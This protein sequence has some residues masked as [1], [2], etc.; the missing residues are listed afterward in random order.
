[1]TLYQLSN[2]Y[3]DIGDG[4][5][6][7]LEND[8]LFQY[9]Y[10]Y[11]SKIIKIYYDKYYNVNIFNEKYFNIKKID[12]GNHIFIFIYNKMYLF[13]FIILNKSNNKYFNYDTNILNKYKLIQLLAHIKTLLGNILLFPQDI[14]DNINNKLKIINSELNSYSD[15]K[16]LYTIDILKKKFNLN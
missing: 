5:M 6:L 9:N 3:I 1:M 10:F 7:L 4:Q 8:N 12:L 13:D 16:V 14:I 15:Q 11:Y 2:V